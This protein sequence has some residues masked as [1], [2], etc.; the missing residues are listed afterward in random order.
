MDPGAACK[1][2]TRFSF[3]GEEFSSFF[4]QKSLCFFVSSQALKK[5][6]TKGYLP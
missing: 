6:T 5:G 2:D 4:K 1:G 3:F